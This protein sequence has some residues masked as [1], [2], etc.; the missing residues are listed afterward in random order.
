MRPFI[1]GPRHYLCPFTDGFLNVGNLFF[2]RLLEFSHF[3]TRNL[4]VARILTTGLLMGYFHCGS[5]RWLECS[6]W[7][8]G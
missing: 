5:T 8:G 3:H 1:R 7:F 2:D 4:P 6:S